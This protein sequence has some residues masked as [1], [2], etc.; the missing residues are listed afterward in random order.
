MI[1]GEQDPSADPSMEVLFAALLA[2]QVYTLK[3]V[4][5]QLLRSASDSKFLDF[6]T[7][8]KKGKG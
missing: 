5:I 3:V 8:A 4:L 1:Y 2:N 6:V 7:S